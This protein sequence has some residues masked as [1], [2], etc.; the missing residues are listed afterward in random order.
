MGF[1]MLTCSALGIII[2]QCQL[3]RMTV[4]EHRCD[5]RLE[6]LQTAWRV[7]Q[8]TCLNLHRLAST[9]EM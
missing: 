1:L 3:M 6:R 8:L 9:S 7:S 2:D 5:N 4:D